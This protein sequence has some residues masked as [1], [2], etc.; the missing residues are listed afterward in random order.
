MEL[1]T[2]IEIYAG[3]EETLFGLVGDIISAGFIELKVSF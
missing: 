2:G 3:P 1:A